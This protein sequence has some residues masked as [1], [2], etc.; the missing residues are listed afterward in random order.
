MGVGSKFTLGSLPPKLKQSYNEVGG[1]IEQS[2]V[3]P[4]RLV[5]GLGPKTQDLPIY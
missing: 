4:F 1:L 2:K 3:N 5:A